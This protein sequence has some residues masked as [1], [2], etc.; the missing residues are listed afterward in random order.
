MR[1]YSTSRPVATRWFMGYQ[2]YIDP[3][4]ES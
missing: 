3:E 1:Q 2:L 4:V